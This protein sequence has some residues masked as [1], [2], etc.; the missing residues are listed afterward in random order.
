MIW[1][2]NLFIF[3]P[4][5]RKP[6]KNSLAE[7]QMKRICYLSDRDEA[8]VLMTLLIG[9]IPKKKHSKIIPMLQFFYIKLISLI[10]VI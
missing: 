7:I 2:R 10:K 9:L 1:A 6:Q 4:Y 5:S 3:P 8:P